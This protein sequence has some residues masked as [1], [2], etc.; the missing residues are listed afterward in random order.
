MTP[1]IYVVWLLLCAGVTYFALTKYAFALTGSLAAAIMWF[2][3]ANASWN[4]E[5]TTG[6]SEPVTTSYPTLAIVGYVAM[7]GM[8][9]AAIIAG[10]EEITPDG[11]RGPQNV[12]EYVDEVMNRV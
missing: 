8:A 11:S 12:A 10:V 5:I 7:L 3:W 1:L 6:A 4:V 9:M 2:V